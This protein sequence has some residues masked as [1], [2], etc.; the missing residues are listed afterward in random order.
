[1]DYDDGESHLRVEKQEWTG[2]K[3]CIDLYGDSNVP[4]TNGLANGIAHDTG[5]VK[6]SLSPYDVLAGV[7]KIMDME[8][9]IAATDQGVSGSGPLAAGLWLS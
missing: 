1:V 3:R 5:P 9:G 6:V 4:E 7:G 8:F 2:A